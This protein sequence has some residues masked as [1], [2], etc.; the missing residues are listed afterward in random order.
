[1]YTHDSI[2]DIKYSSCMKEHLKISNFKNRNFLFFVQVEAAAHFGNLCI[3][4]KKGT[5]Y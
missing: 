1:M 2:K 4:L 3:P 5:R